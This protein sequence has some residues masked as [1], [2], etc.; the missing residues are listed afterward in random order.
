MNVGKMIQ[1]LRKK[2]NITQEDLAAQLGITA[3]AVS[4]WENG[5]TLPDILMLC[6]IA[7]LFEVTTDELLGRNP[8][9]KYA[10]I[11]TDSQTLGIG[12]KEKAKSYGFSVKEI[13]G[14][15][16][17]AL[18]I[19]KNDPSI[20][21]LFASFENPLSEEEKGEMPDSLCCVESHAS[22]TEKAL[23]GFDIYFRNMSAYDSLIQ[24]RPTNES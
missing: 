4:K 1:E 9:V 7:D 22:K 6:A 15:L 16:A 24:K 2:R 12:L 18:Q 8:K 17:N 10:V 19:A 14:S 13:C 5:Y 23:D 11:A 3:A 20:T 21:H